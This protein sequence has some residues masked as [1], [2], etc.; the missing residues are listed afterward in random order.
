MPTTYE[1]FVAINPVGVIDRNVWDDRIAEVNMQFV[2]GPTI[3]TP[4]ID[5]TD[6]SAVTGASKSIYSEM[7]EGDVDF[8]EIEHNAKYIEEPLG[9]DS[10]Q[11][12]IGTGRYGDKIQVDDDSSVFQ[13]WKLS[14]GRDWRPLLRGVL[15]NNVRRKMEFVSR[16]AYLKGPKE[17]WTY[18]G[19]ATSWGTLDANCKFDIDI[20]T[21]WNLRLGNT[22]TPIIPGDMAAAK[23]AIIPPGVTY[24]FRKSL[25]AATGNEAALFTQARLY[26]GESIRYEMGTYEGVRFVEVPNDTYGFN[27]A[28]LYNC[29]AIFAQA[30]AMA[31]ITMGAGAP[32]PETTKVDSVWAVGQKD[33]THYIQLDTG[34]AADF[35][36]N[37]WVT[38]HIARTN[39]YGVTN[40]VDPL[41]GKTIVR[42]VV[43]VDTSND[44][45]SFDRPIMRNYT[46]NLGSG[47]Y[48]YVTKGQHVGF[49]LV[50]GS[51]GGILGNVNRPIKFYEPKSIDD[52][53]SIYRLVWDIRAGLNIWEPNLWECHFVA[54]SVAKPGGIN[55]PQAIGS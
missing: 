12:D 22:G 31:A 44:T 18:G 43:A 42:R 30:T 48:A 27:A 25:A 40:G 7:M 24:D 26:Q 32:N 53:E 20:T 5:W 2:K 23:V 13:M 33:V 11:R 38:I 3:Y 41:S 49:C 34:Q 52:F 54:V 51:R 10:R 55:S 8:D 21:D 17:F 9:I 4:L 50:L 1:D 37:D 36:K 45:L 28:V 15:G 46:N 14:G 29:G 16:N 39:A 47:V 6:R 35:A 19:A